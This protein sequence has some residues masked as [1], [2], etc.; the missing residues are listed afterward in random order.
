M[1]KLRTY[2]E[3]QRQI[4]GLL[5]MRKRLPEFTAFGDN[6]WKTIDTQIAVLKGESEPDDFYQDESDEDYED[7]DNQLYHDADRADQWLNGD[8]EEDLFDEED[9]I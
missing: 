3:I 6:N 9:K 5:R 1:G 4:A 8:E 7:G 2:E